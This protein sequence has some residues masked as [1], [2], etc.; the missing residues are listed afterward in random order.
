MV[1]R[2]AKKTRGSEMVFDLPPRVFYGK[3]NHFHAP[4]FTAMTMDEVFLDA[5]APSEYSASGGSCKADSVIYLS[6]RTV[7]DG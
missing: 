1:S 5:T 6:G 2:G 7:C 4:F 3:I